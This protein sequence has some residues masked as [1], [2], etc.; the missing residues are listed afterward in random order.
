MFV[1]GYE[2]WSPEEIARQLSGENIKLDDP[3]GLHGAVIVLCHRVAELTARL[4]ATDG[5]AGRALD[6]AERL[7]DEDTNTSPGF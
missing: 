3:E 4:K 7:D 6:I 5:V 2:D 1:S